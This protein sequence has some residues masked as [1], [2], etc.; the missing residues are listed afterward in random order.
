MHFW[1]FPGERDDKTAGEKPVGIHHINIVVTDLGES[2]DFFK[3]FGF[4]VVHE[5]TIHGDWLDRVTGLKDVAANYLS[6]SHEDSSVNLELLQ[7]KNPEGSSDPQISSPNHIGYRHL[8]LDVVNI[9][10]ELKRLTELGVEFLGEIQVN[11]YGRKMCY[12][13]GPDGILL[14]LIQL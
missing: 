12:F 10:V 13:T 9:E 2:G 5:K 8:A 4:T 7:F 3:L 1:S 6:L 11:S 14:E